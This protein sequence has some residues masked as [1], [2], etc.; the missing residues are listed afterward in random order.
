MRAN[1]EK[2]LFE[3]KQHE[4]FIHS[5]ME[6]RVENG[7]SLPTIDP[8][9]LIGRTYIELPQDDGT[10]RRVTIKEVTPEYKSEVEIAPDLYKFKCQVGQDQFEEIMTYNQ[11]RNHVEQSILKEGMSEYLE[12]ID[13]REVLSKKGTPYKNPRWEVHLHW[14]DGS[15]TWEPLDSIAEHDHAACALFASDKTHNGERLIDQPGW[16]RFKKLAGRT[17]KLYRMINQAKL[18]S[19]Q[20][21]PVYQYGIQVPRNHDKAVR[22][23]QANGNTLWLKAERLEL[24]QLDEYKAFKDLGRDTKAPEGFKKIRVHFVYACPDW[25]PRCRSRYDRWLCVPALRRVCLYRFA[26]R[27]HLAAWFDAAVTLFNICAMR[28]KS[29]VYIGQTILRR[30]R[31]RQICSGSETEL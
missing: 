12:I 20:T 5:V 6:K 25:Q 9:E 7:G 30:R 27:D 18:H 31:N 21:K 14:D 2:S 28:S 3:G 29:I 17:K 24:D 16:Q 22:I 15:R 10:Q 23:D 8:S 19:N 1:Y 11:M 13:F 4:Q 26:Q